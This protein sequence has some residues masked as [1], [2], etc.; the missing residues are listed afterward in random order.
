[1]SRLRR[2]LPRLPRTLIWQVISLLLLALVSAQLAT[3]AILSGERRSAVDA[4]AREQ[5][6]ERAAALVRLVET[7]ESAGER[8][9]ALRAFS[10]SDLRF[11][12]ADE[13]A[14]A[15][16]DSTRPGPLA[17][18]LAAL[19][20]D[21]QPREVL[22]AF[23]EVER[24]GDDRRSRWH[25]HW[26]R[27]AA[28]DQAHGEPPPPRLPDEGL[29]LAIN[30]VADQRAQTNVQGKGDSWLNAAMVL[31]PVQ[32]VLGPAPL[33][34]LIVAAIA[35]SLVA[36]LSLRRL[37][38]P[39]D[40]LA[41]AADAVGRGEPARLEAARG[42]VEIR[43]TASAF[44]EMQ[45][46]IARSMAD[47]TRLLAAISHDLRTPITTLRL[48]AELVEDDELRE[49][50][51]ATLDEMQALTEAGLL[52]A[53][54]TAA[55]EPSRS[56]DLVALV[57]SVVADL[58]DQGHDVRLE[59]GPAATLRCRK[60]ALTRAIRNVVENAVRYGGNATIQITPVPG[61]L[62]ILIE[63]DGPGLPQSALEQVFEPFFRLEASRSRETGGS[64]L[65]LAIARSII[66]EHGGD[67]TLANRSEGGLRA[68]IQL[69]TGAGPDA[70][71]SD[72]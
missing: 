62:D 59:A 48:R 71:A 50:I 70:A 69:P 23:G 26:R 40:A 30:L 2:L 17:R 57:E 16:S 60:L 1:M 39:L 28:K 72:I 27:A 64:G 42:P 52:L 12:L 45:A 5:V 6:L 65:G 18:R 4:F 41:V 32:P 54:D 51:L 15:A 11:W 55:E 38:R 10:T 61:S 66:R 35:I 68:T 44:N 36:A 56:I 24:R 47:R 19:L 53:R 29:L 58:V 34:S 14:V 3:F 22:I 43:R 37:I 46:R 63:D 49:K 21:G 7:T 67:V 31:P 8:R 20:D 13:P 9:R 25:D 33:V